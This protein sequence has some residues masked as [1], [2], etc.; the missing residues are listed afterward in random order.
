MSSDA[1]QKPKNSAAA[2]RITWFAPDRP[3]EN[4]TI[5]LRPEGAPSPVKDSRTE[6]HPDD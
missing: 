1:G 6:R 3:V 2:H 5:F 4:G